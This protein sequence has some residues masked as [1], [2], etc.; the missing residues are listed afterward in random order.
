[1]RRGEFI[2]GLGVT[3]AWPLPAR[4]RLYARATAF[5][6]R[7]GLQLIVDAVKRM[8]RAP[9]KAHDLAARFAPWR[10]IDAKMSRPDPGCEFVHVTLTA[11]NRWGCIRASARYRAYLGTLRKEHG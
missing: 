11:G 6:A 1:M 5:A 7:E 2:A 4:R 9:G 10:R 3:A 8:R